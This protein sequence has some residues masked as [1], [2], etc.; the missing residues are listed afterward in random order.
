MVLGHHFSPQHVQA[1]KKPATTRRLLI[2]N[3]FGRNPMRKIT[4]DLG[5]YIGVRGQFLNVGSGQSITQSLVFGRILVCSEPTP[6][7][8]RMSE[9]RQE[10]FSIFSY[11]CAFRFVLRTRQRYEKQRDRPAFSIKKRR[12]DMMRRFSDN[13]FSTTFIQKIYFSHKK[14]SSLHRHNHSGNRIDPG[15]QTG[16]ALHLSTDLPMHKKLSSPL[17]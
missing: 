16:K 9:A 15:H 17:V 13:T 4:V 6:P 1:R 7:Q 5:T 3:S 12:I 11:S 8:N 2:G 14:A 10:K